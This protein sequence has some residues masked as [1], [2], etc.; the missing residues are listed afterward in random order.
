MSTYNR[1]NTMTGAIESILTQTEHDFEFIIIDDGSTDNTLTILKEYQRKD[2][3]IKILE[4][5]EN[6]GLIYSLNR[7]L[8]VAK[9]EFVA[10]MDDDDVSLPW[11]FERQLLAMKENPDIIL[12]GTRITSANANIKKTT[13]PSVIENPDVTQLNS[14]TS[15]GLAHPTIMFRKSFLDKHHIQYRSDN[16]YAEDCGL[17]ADIWNAGGKISN[18]QEHLLRYGVKENVKKPSKYGHIQYNTFKKIQREK[19]SKLF[20]PEEHLLGSYQSLLSRCELWDKMIQSNPGKNILNQEVL[21]ETFKKRCPAE[22]KNA[23]FVKHD[24][25]E[26]FLVYEADNRLRRYSNN[27]RATVIQKND[28]DITIKWDQYGTETFRINDKHQFV[29]VKH[30]TQ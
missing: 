7:G 24:F 19:I 5:G 22:Y 10:R 23:L 28:H 26:D 11:R 29:L 17:Y 30:K 2:P 9:G 8:S 12:M 20:E 13:G 1:A 21:E 15:S 14:Y 4:N 18:L 25:W 6:Q 3:R 16:L 27:N